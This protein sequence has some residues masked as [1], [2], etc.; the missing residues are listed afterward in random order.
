MYG[1]AGVLWYAAFHPDGSRIV[2]ASNNGT[3]QVFNIFATTQAMIDHA[4]GL[5]LGEL[6]KAQREAYFIFAP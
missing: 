2:T 4:I 5:K 1:Q 3:V 6:T